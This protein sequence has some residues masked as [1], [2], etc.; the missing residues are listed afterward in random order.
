MKRII[1]STILCLGLFLAL[2]T[3]MAVARPVSYPGGW[4]F[5]TENDGEANSALV[6]YTVTPKTAFGYRVEYDRSTRATF[7]GVQMNNLLQRWNN[8]ASQANIYLKS[9]VG[10][11]KDDPEAFTGIQADWENRRYM[12]MYENRAMLSQ[13]DKRQMFHQEVGFGIAPYVAEFGS[14]HTWIMA[15]VRHHPEDEKPFQFQPM[16]RFFKGTIL[17]E[18]GYNVTTHA[19]VAN[20]MIRF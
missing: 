3:Q 13:D 11:A 16:L 6:H 1:L 9:A 8:P 10:V 18:T 4:T 19:P 7:N 2:S 5:I 12:V 17:V 14:F 15:H 20:A